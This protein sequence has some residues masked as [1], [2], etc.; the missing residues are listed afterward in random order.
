VTPDAPTAVTTAATSI[1]STSATL[2]GS[3]NPNRA[4]T[5]GYFRYATTSPGTCNTHVGDTL[6]EGPGVT[7][8]LLR[9]HGVEVRPVEGRRM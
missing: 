6:V 4:T 7:T 3:G 8:E 2:N 9:R 1:A 5:T